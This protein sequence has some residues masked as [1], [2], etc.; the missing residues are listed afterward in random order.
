MREFGPSF[1]E[2]LAEPAPYFGKRWGRYSC[3]T[4]HSLL[5]GFRSRPVP[6]RAPHLLRLQ[7]FGRNERRR[8]NRGNNERYERGG[9]HRD[10][11]HGG[12]EAHHG[13]DHVLRERQLG[14][15][16]HRARREWPRATGQ[17]RAHRRTRGTNA[18]RMGLR[19]RHPR[20]FF[21]GRLAAEPHADREPCQQRHQSLLLQA[22]E[23]RVHR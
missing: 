6:G 7:R 2:L 9:R 18:E 14:R 20:A 19:S 3:K 15:R 22:V 8:G 11:H 1:A 21:L 5:R 13:D 10:A 16:R 12:R 4:S 23:Q 17:L